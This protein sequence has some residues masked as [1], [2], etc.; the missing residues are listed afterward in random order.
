[1]NLPSDIYVIYFQQC[2]TYT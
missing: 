2:R 1:M